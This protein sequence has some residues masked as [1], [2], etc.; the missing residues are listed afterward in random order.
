MRVKYCFVTGLK[1]SPYVA[2]KSGLLLFGTA[3]VAA[4]VI[5]EPVNPPHIACPLAHG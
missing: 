2:A 4:V 5:G 1:K 3:S